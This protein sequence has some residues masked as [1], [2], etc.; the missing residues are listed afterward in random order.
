MVSLAEQI[1]LWERQ[2]CRV[3]S[4]RPHHLFT[5]DVWEDQVAVTLRL[6]GAG[7]GSFPIEVD[8]SGREGNG[9]GSMAS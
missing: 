9:A 1:R 6:L 2:H 8:G 5:T 7:A 3:P 4:L